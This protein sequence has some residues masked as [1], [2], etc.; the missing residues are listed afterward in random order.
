LNPTGSIVVMRTGGGS[1]PS[2]AL[3]SLRSISGVVLVSADANP[4]SVGFHA[5][6]HAV[7]IPYA[8]DPGFVDAM[9]GVC[10]RLR[11][12]VLL[13]AVDEELVLLSRASARFAE[14]GTRVL[15]SP[16]EVL[17]SCA[18]KWLFHQRLTE[19]GV[20][21]PRTWLPE[22]EPECPPPWIVKP[23]RGRG[24]VGV[25][26]V[27]RVE[28]LDAA[29]AG[30]GDAMVQELVPGEEYTVDTLSDLQGRFLYGSPRVRLKTES[31]VSTV[32]RTK[33]DPAAMESVARLMERLGIQ[34]P[35]NLQY[36]RS[37]ADR[38]AVLEINPRLSGGGALTEGAG[39]PYLED[40]LRV[41]R[42]EPVPPRAAREGVTMLR[43]WR[44][45]FVEPDGSA[46][47]ATAG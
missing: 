33:A 15:L 23:R 20:P 46:G 24:S 17:E 25:A 43:E 39:I 45:V 37:A 8:S 32:G 27:D 34:G 42:G 16:P 18:D 30:A 29:V 28:E 14:I 7:T 13:P 4:V 47:A 9:L 26:R 6:H 11:V 41:V 19:I 1:A 2:W 3:H 12:D 21:G 36:I 35:A 22:M 38:F 44:E 40:V 10:Q 5:A 31:G